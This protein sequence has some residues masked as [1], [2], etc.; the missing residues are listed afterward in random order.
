[1][2]YKHKRTWIKIC[3]ATGLLIVII[4]V[5]NII[6][7]SVV[8]KKLRTS[9]QQFQPY[10]QA[11]FS[12]A[13][14][15]LFAA[16]VQL[17]S[18][19]ILYNPELKKEHAHSIN[20]SV[21]EIS[22]IHFFKLITAKEFLAGSLQ[23]K[24]ANIK[25]DYYLL[26]KHDTLPADIFKKINAPFKNIFFNSVELKD[27]KIFEQNYKRIDAICSG[28]FLLSDVRIPNINSTFSKDSIHFSNV[29]CELNEIHYK[30]S[31]YYS[32][33]VKKILL[34]SKDS[35]L[36]LDSLKLI[37]LLNKFEMGEKLKR[38]ADHVNAIIR[39]I[40]I[41]GLYAADLLHQK[42]IADKI[43]IE[44]PMA[45]IFRDRRLPRSKEKQPTPLDYLKQIPFNVSVQHFNLNDAEITSEEFPK[46][47]EHSGY[48]KLQHLY[49]TMK[50]FINHTNKLSSSVISNV[51]TS[52]MGAGNIHATIKLSLVN[53]NSDIKGA[54]E[55]L[56][57]TAMNP[58]AE[59]LGKFHIESGVLN[60]LDFQ[61]TATDVKATG[62]IVGVYHDLVVDRL[63]ETKHGLKK[64][65]I[66][67]FLLHKIIIPKNKDASLDIK[68]RTG[69]IDYN[70]DPTRFI[71]FYYLK[72]LLDGIRDS[73]TLG[74]VL[75]E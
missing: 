45:Y 58:S 57:L 40:K 38:Q 15:N 8:E 73:F 13:H 32:V 9:L 72:A 11:N 5:A 37:P 2:K 35:L 62:K 41:T 68:K 22:G 28:N 74:F 49:V 56:N 19:N 16:S 75:P 17:D 43:N 12:K 42:F 1:M 29:N 46:E 14:I 61:F 67:S 66:A 70:R 3:I 7:K 44:K 47:G 30:L 4:V 48:I 39:Q 34:N 36:Q 10:I 18:L 24:N 51:K 31:D 6:L 25:L 27:M 21:A 63:K 55:E 54:I 20:F 52:I 33:S 71:T 50:P 65:S 26:D 53:G 23:L 69:K 64:A 60:R 59:N